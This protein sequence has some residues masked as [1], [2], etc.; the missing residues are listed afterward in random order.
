MNNITITTTITITTKAARNGFITITSAAMARIIARLGGAYTWDGNLGYTEKW[1][2][3]SGQWLRGQPHVFRSHRQHGD[4]YV[5]ETIDEKMMERA[6]RSAKWG[7]K[8]ELHDHRDCDEDW[9]R[10][11]STSTL[12]S[13]VKDG[14]RVRASDYAIWHSE[15]ARL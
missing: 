11:A 13:R 2:E 15:D 5:E 8:I 9:T 10:E 1:I 3:L 6:L 7:S 12:G 4:D 14:W